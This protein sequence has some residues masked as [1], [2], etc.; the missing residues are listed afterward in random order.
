MVLA[1]GADQS[2]QQPR[3]LPAR[4]EHLASQQVQCLD[5]IGALVDAGNARVAESLLGAGLADVAVAAMHL[6][7]QAGHLHRHVRVERLDDRREDGEQVCRL[8]PFVGVRVVLGLVHFHARE[9]GQQSA[10]L[11]VG[12]LRHQHPPHI[13][14]LDDEVRRLIRRRAAAGR[15]SLA[16]LARVGQGGL[17]RQFGL[18]KALQ[19]DPEARVVHHHE[20]ALQAGIR[21]A[22]HPALR[23]FEGHDAGG[24]TVDAHL[25]LEPRAAHA[26][27]GTG[28]AVLPGQL[29][30]HQ[31]QADAAGPAG[32][33]RQPGQHQVDDVLGKVVIAARD[34]DLL[35]GDA[36][37]AV[38]VGLGPG[39]Q[40]PQVG[41][42]LGFR[43][44]HGAAPL[45]R[46]QLREIDLLQRLRCV[47]LQAQDRA[48]GE[49]AVQLPGHV[50]RHQHLADRPAEAFRQSL[51]AEFGRTA[52]CRPAILDKAAIGLLEARR[53][54][55][56]VALEADTD[57]VARFVRRR[58]DFL[59]KARR[60]LQ[61]A[62]DELHVEVVPAELG[63]VA[64]SAQYFMNHESHVPDGGG[65]A[66]HGHMALR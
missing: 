37:G 63:V 45:A 10:A 59:G 26:V 20:H 12:L 11:D 54:D 14:V 3:Q 6:D 41:A 46:D 24:R 43:Q 38:V 34:E 25:F 18:R 5:A 58:H 2:A 51:A 15:A 33:V 7:S 19:P 35:A 50:G 66:M 8:L 44:A 49:T 57:P 29:F 36:V 61:H 65:V 4:A 21:L 32:C 13:G 60:F 53:R 16:A 48:V 64:F 1:E 56:V 31:E 17:P 28:R 39:A 40:Q 55:D 47:L 30:R 42:R 9:V 52:Q 62:V 22:D 23:P 27:C